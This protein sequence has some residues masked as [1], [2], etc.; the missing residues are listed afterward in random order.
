[1]EEVGGNWQKE[2]IIWRELVKS[3]CNNLAQLGESFVLQFLSN[4]L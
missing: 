3:C 1:M 2:S 4:I